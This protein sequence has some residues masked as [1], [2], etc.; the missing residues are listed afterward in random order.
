[1]IQ[2]HLV[3]KSSINPTVLSQKCNMWLFLCKQCMKTQKLTN[4]K[5]TQKFEESNLLYFSLSICPNTFS[6]IYWQIVSQS[7]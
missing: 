7:S 6:L 2:C 4:E 3:S 5:S 1:M